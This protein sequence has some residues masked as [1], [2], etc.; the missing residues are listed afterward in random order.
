ME[1]PDDLIERIYATMQYYANETT[2]QSPRIGGVLAGCP[3]G[4]VPTPRELT[5][6]AASIVRQMED[7]LRP[8]A[9]LIGVAKRSPLDSQG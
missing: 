3:R 1:V 5:Y 8:N 2:Y 6:E 4:A 7:A 9:D